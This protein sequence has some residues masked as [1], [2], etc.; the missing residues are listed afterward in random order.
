MISVIISTYNDDEVCLAHLK[1]CME[2][3]YVPE[4]II[5]VDDCGKEGLLDKIKR[6]KRNTKIIYARV[7]E[8]IKWNYTGA[9]NLGIW[10]SRG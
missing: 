2:S 9:R 4:E 6:L 8:D 5:V 3:S 10:L 7:L 1:T